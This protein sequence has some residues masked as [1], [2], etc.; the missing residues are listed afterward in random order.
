MKQPVCQKVPV[1]KTIQIF[2]LRLFYFTHRAS[3]FSPGKALDLVRAALQPSLNAELESVL[4]SY[5]EVR[6]RS[7]HSDNSLQCV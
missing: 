5:Q 6:V 2:M 7:V 1:N 4:K 3:S